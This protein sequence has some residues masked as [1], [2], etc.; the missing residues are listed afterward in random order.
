MHRTS[1][2]QAGRDCDVGEKASISRL[3]TSDVEARRGELLDCL[4]ESLRASPIKRHTEYHLRGAEVELQRACDY[5]AS[6]HVLVCETDAGA[7]VGLTITSRNSEKASLPGDI[8]TRWPGFGAGATLLIWVAV[9]PSRRREGHATRL[10]RSALEGH[11]TAR[12]YLYVDADNAPARRLYERH[13]WFRLGEHRS[14]LLLGLDRQPEDPGRYHSGI[15][16]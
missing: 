5:P 7:L 14:D 16:T 15:I 13:G 10:V 9:L 8:E 3:T 2:T 12:A 4:T 6:Y 1:G 11:G